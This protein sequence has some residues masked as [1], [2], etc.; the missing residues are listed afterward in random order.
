MKHLL[1]L[2]PLACTVGI[3]RAQD[4]IVKKDSSTVVCRVKELTRTDVVYKKWSDQNGPD[5]VLDKSLVY[6]VNYENGERV[7]FTGE[8]RKQ[9]LLTDVDN[10]HRRVNKVLLKAGTEIP[11]YCNQQIS[12]QKVKVGHIITFKVQ[13]NIIVDGVVVIPRETVVEG[14]CYEA[15]SA[16]SEAFKFKSRKGSIGVTIKNIVLPNG[17]VIEVNG[18]VRGKVKRSVV[19]GKRAD[20]IPVG[21]ETN[22]VVSKD[23][24]IIQ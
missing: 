17:S 4:V 22:I 12:A 9:V 10:A 24:T 15:N 18:D 2:L 13:R 1:A 14:E 16:W 11:I 5:Y 20:I 21:Y 3:V 23:A 8:E 7:Y 6:C 19:V